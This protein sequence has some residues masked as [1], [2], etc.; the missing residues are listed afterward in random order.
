MPDKHFIALLVLRADNIPRVAKRFL[1][2]NQ[3]FVTVTDQ[4]TTK[5]TASVSIKG[6]TVLWNKTFDAL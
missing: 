3:F 2:K 1:L 6:Q 4:A 5:K